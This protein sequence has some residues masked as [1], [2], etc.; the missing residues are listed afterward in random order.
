MKEC[1]KIRTRNSKGITLI[2]LV[3]TII[4]LLILAG[5]SIAM[6]TGDNGILTQANSANENTKIANE[7]ER[8]NLASSGAL[9]KDNGE[10]MIQD[11][12]EDELEKY[13]DKSD[14]SVTTGR[15]NIGEEGFIVTI[16]ENVEEGRKY[17]VNG[18]GSVKQYEEP[19]IA[20]LTDIYVSLY[21]DGTLVFSN[22]DQLMEGKTLEKSYG[23]IKDEVFDAKEDNGEFSIYIPWFEV[24]SSNDIEDIMDQII[25]Q[26]SKIQKV[27]IANK[28]VPKNTRLWFSYLVNIEEIEGIENLDTSNVTDMNCMFCRL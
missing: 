9:L 5:V 26:S 6:L 23:N 12:L 25:N 24:N 15:N 4:V 18:K 7:K 14:F 19:Q 10:K 3:I 27:I 16:T 1:K 13:F 22:N 17:F 21:T 28:I 2:A 11:N 20:E 8:V